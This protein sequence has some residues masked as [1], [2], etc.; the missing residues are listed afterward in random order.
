MSVPSNRMA[1]VSGPGFKDP[2]KIMGLPKWAFWAVIAVGVILA[3]YIYKKSQ[4]NAANS[5]AS[6][7]SDA[8][9][10][11]TAADIGGTPA[12]NSFATNTDL[13]SLEEQI[14]QM[15]DSIQQ[16]EASG[17]GGGAGIGPGNGSTGTPYPVGIIP[18]TTGTLPP[19]TGVPIT[20]GNPPVLTTPPVRTTSPFLPSPI[21]RFTEGMPGDYMTGGG[22][23][24]SPTANQ[25][26][27]AAGIH[28]S[29]V[30][31]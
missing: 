21:I 17:G 30:H 25:N 14:Q 13:T 11:L 1:P 29:M 26:L 3:F 5:A 20:S 27:I 4:S 24:N 23:G 10:G 9:Q 16:L 28:P 6:T 15:E 7:N 31:A 8:D 19:I 2:N 18:P 22:V 12:D